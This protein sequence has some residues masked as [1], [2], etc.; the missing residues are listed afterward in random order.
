MQIF[1]KRLSVLKTKSLIRDVSCRHNSEH[2]H[3]ASWKHSIKKMVCS[4][5]AS[6][7]SA[8]CSPISSESS[9]LCVLLHCG[10]CSVYKSGGDSEESRNF[11]SVYICSW[12][13]LTGIFDSCWPVCSSLSCLT[14]STPCG[15]VLF[16]VFQGC[17]GV[18]YDWS[19]SVWICTGTF[20]TQMLH[21]KYY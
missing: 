11:S 5:R 14:L 9:L 3:W 20:M 8:A 16:L 7:S 18:V 1:T 19:V 6:W 15:T 12:L 4:V 13:L 10:F 2:V 21:D 17:S